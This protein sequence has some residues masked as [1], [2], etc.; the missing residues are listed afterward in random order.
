M[1]AEACCFYLI[2]PSLYVQIRSILRVS[3]WQLLLP[4][5]LPAQC[6]STRLVPLQRCLQH[7]HKELRHT[8]RY[9]LCPGPHESN[10]VFKTHFNIILPFLL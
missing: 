8:T 10:P 4:L 5:A 1:Q 9:H 2:S 3:S 6:Y 7:N